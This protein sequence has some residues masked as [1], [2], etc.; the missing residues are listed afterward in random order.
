MAYA[1]GRSVNANRVRYAL[2]MVIMMFTSVNINLLVTDLAEAHQTHGNSSTVYSWPLSGHNDTGWVTLEATNADPESGQ[3]A[4]QDWDILFPPGAEVSNVSMEIMVDGSSGISIYEPHLFGE[5]TGETFFDWSGN[6]GFG[7]QDNLMGS[8]PHTGRLAPFSDTGATW[9]LPAGASVTDLTIEA[10][11]PLDPVVSFEPLDFKIGDYE[12]DPHDGRMYV[13][14]ENSILQLDFHS[15]PHAIHF[16][17]IGQGVDVYDIEIDAS[18]NL[19]LVATSDGITS[20]SLDDGQEMQVYP[21]RPASLQFDS[22]VPFRQIAVTTS[23][24]YAIAED[25]LFKYSSVTNTWALER[26]AGTANWPA[27]NPVDTLE[28]GGN[29]LVALYGG[30]VA[31]WNLATGSP[32]NLWS[33]SNNLPS[34]NVMKLLISGGEI[35]VATA[36][37]GIGRYDYVQGFWKSPWTTSNGLSSNSV[38]GIEYSTSNQ[39]NYVTILTEDSLDIYNTQSGAF[40]LPYGLNSL[41][42]YGSGKM[43][44]LMWPANNG[45]RSPTGLIDNL[46]VS[47]GSGKLARLTISP[48]LL[49]NSGIYQSEILLASG[50]SSNQMTD[51]VQ[52]DSVVWVGS[53]SI[54]DRYDTVEGRWLQTIDVGDDIV[55]LTTDGTTVYAATTSSDIMT[56]SID[57]TSGILNAQVALNTGEEILDITWDSMT[58]MLVTSHVTGDEYSVK[59]INPLTSQI[60]STWDSASLG[61]VM[62]T[63]LVVRDA[64]A[65]VAT[66]DNGILRIDMTTATLLSPWISTGL[67]NLEDMPIT[68]ANGNV[69]LGLYDYGVMVLNQTT[70]ELVDLWQD[71]GTNIQTIPN[72]AITA[73][74]ADMY[75]NIYVGTQEGGVRWDTSGGWTDIP[76]EQGGSGW[77]G[78]WY[79]DDFRSFDSDSNWLWA[80]FGE[81]RICRWDLNTLQG[82]TGSN[83]F[84]EDNGLPDE[85]YSY[86]RVRYVA[87]DRVLVTSDDG[88]MIFDTVNETVEGSWDLGQETLNAVTAQ[89]DDIIYAAYVGIG[90]TRY[91]ISTSSW[92]SSWNN[93]NNILPNDEV[94]TLQVDTNNPNNL[95]VGGSFGLMLINSSTSAVEESFPPGS[96][97]SGSVEL[98]TESPQELIIHNNI[99]YYITY[100]DGWDENGIIAR[101][102]LTSMTSLSEIDVSQKLGDD[103]WVHSA[104]MSGDIL[105]IGVSEAGWQQ[106]N[107]GGIFRWNTSSDTWDS[108]GHILEPTEPIL[109]VNANV[110]GNY[111]YVAYGTDSVKQFDLQGNLVN[112]WDSNTVLGPIRDIEEY[113]GLV[114]FASYDGIAR[115]DPVNGT[116]LQ[117]MNSGDGSDTDGDGMPDSLPSES[118][119]TISA[120]EIV[121]GDIWFSSYNTEWWNGG[122][123]S[124]VFRYESSTSSWD[125][126]EDGSQGLPDGVAFSFRECSGILHIGMIEYGGNS[127]G[128]GRYKLS[129]DTWEPEWNR[130][131]GGQGQSGGLESN[132]VMG[133]ACDDSGVVYVGYGEMSG[134]GGG[135]GGGGGQ[136]IPGISRYSYSQGQWLSQLDG[137]N[138][139]YENALFYDAMDWMDGELVIGHDYDAGGNGGISRILANGTN[140]GA[141]QHFST[142]L[143]ASTAIPNRGNSL[144]KGWIIG[145]PGSDSGFSRV[146]WLAHGGQLIPGRF[147]AQVGITSG[148][149]VE[150]ESNGTHVYVVP[151]ESE[152]DY[153]GR[154][155]LEGVVLANGS[156]EWTRAWTFSNLDIIA[157]IEFVGTELWITTYGLGLWKVD[158]NTGMMSRISASISSFMDGLFVNGDILSIGVVGTSSSSAG[159]QVYNISSSS[160]ISGSLLAGLPSD[161]IRDGVIHSGKIWFATDNGVGIWNISTQEWESALTVLNGLPTPIIEEIYV[162]D[163]PSGVSELW[164]ATPVGLV[165]YNPT[166]STFSPTIDRL[167]G[168]VG[169]SVSHVVEDGGNLFL[170]HTGRGMTRPGANSLNLSTLL[171]EET[172]R[173]DQLPSNSI[174]SMAV[175]AWGIHIATDTDPITHWN[176]ATNQFEDGASSWQFG[177]W[178]PKEMVSD[179]S[180]L[181]VLF[182]NKLVRVSVQGTTHSILTT[183]SPFTSSNSVSIGQN[184]LFVVGSD[185]MW[186]WEG[187]P[188]FAPM[189]RL[190]WRRAV[191]LTAQFSGI[192]KDLSNSIHPGQT[193]T[194]V[195]SDNSSSAFSNPILIEPDI[196]D[197]GD[198]SYIREVEFP[199]ILTSDVANSPTWLSSIGM[200]YSGIWNLTEENGELDRQL[201]DMLDIS[202]I[203]ISG[204]EVT[205]RLTAPMNGS[206]MVR[207]TYD[208]ERTQTPVSGI[209][210]IDR[211]DDGGQH[212]QAEWSNA[213]DPDFA[214]YNLYLKEDGWDEHPLDISD[215]ASTP[216][217]TSNFWGKSQA[218]VN[219]AAGIPLVDGNEYWAV[220]VVEYLDG[221]FGIPSHPFGPAI[222]TDEIP[223]PPEWANAGPS[224]GG[225]DGDMYVEWGGCTSIDYHSTRIYTS[226]QLVSDALGLNSH[227]NVMKDEGN[228]TLLQVQAGL[229]YW[230]ALTCVDDAGQ[231]DPANATV[232][233][234]IVPAGGLND[235][236]APP[237]IEDIEAFDTPEDEGGRITV[238]WTPSDE[239]DCMLHTILIMDSTSSDVIP[240]TA[241]EFSVATVITDCETGETIISAIGEEPLM[242]G[243]MYYIT[244]VAADKWLNEDRINVQIV[245]ATPFKTPGMEATKPDRVTFL[246]AWDVADDD[247]SAINVGWASSEADDFSHY[248]IWASSAPV[249]DLRDAWELF[250]DDPAKCACITVSNQWIGDKETPLTVV[251]NKAIYSESLHDD[252]L[253]N[254]E[255]LDIQPDETLYVTVTVHDIKGNVWLNELPWVE[256]IPVDNRDDMEAPDRLTDLELVDRPGDDGTSLELSFEKSTSSD[257]MKYAIYADTYDFNEVGSA[258]T[259]SEP[260]FI[261]ERDTNQWNFG[262]IPNMPII[263]DRLSSGEEI[264]PMM[265]VYVAVVAI[266][267]NDNSHTDNLVSVSATSKDNRNED[268][269]AYLPDIVGV[270]ASWVEGG[271]TIYVQW[272]SSSDITVSSYMIFISN[273]EWSNTMDAIHVGTAEG[274][275]IK[276][277][278]LP[279]DPTNN[280]IFPTQI[281]NSTEWWIAVVAADDNEHRHIVSSPLPVFLS[282]YVSSSASDVS[283]EGAGEGSPFDMQILN[284]PTMIITIALLISI[285]IVL[286]LIYRTRSG[287][288]KGGWEYEATW[289]IKQ[290][291][292]DAEWDS[293]VGNTPSG[294]PP[295]SSNEL[296]Q[297]EPIPSTVE[298]TTPKTENYTS[299]A[300]GRTY[301]VRSDELDNL[302][303]D[304]FDE[305][306]KDDGK[307]DTSFLDDLL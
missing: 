72:N 12:I 173:L 96:S 22:L 273:K 279:A 142:D 263:V 252:K 131:Q 128:V 213:P 111:M 33:S 87:Q 256:V 286:L 232:I 136:G 288:K 77:G 54:I 302:A 76:V 133:L 163:S 154:S 66:A 110:I 160:W 261:I 241:E 285:L 103:A 275:N 127:G 190:V 280:E 284:D 276:I 301:S 2:I 237:P 50:P 194:F 137:S 31:S 109:R 300:S 27:G 247:G 205:F 116:W 34:D 220:V 254:A 51:V 60:V 94:S 9:M 282:A 185:G 121:N 6:G 130:G 107:P 106:P 99:M 225:S 14:I 56:Y 67:D 74:H 297:S 283:D 140:V 53:G 151:A 122:T 81:A 40:E 181:F 180:N 61:E 55:A 129:T 188:T 146:D 52:M 236:I 71:S 143:E 150:I 48:A 292:G 210:L 41:N 238:K 218:L 251:M 169:N 187:A 172:Y 59:F 42:L 104:G 259:P 193:Y 165:R 204:M 214:K 15:D 78:S 112:E 17:E 29:L 277:G 10:L 281:D 244:V 119:E 162:Y 153:A 198:S 80:S 32:N 171:V 44:L 7:T 268:P 63:D 43:N 23:G 170:S 101:L 271:T 155:V 182:N 289:G 49:Q 161:N 57:P 242:D 177:A 89:I 25:G 93:A 16:R 234:P 58:G 206:M 264:I 65:Y 255:V 85:D 266:D 125:N 148:V 229:P 202:Q 299:V 174:I 258:N 62:I 145:R 118:E 253:L 97:N 64:I 91:D 278:E 199:M 248:I 179:G 115:Y 209:S 114:L 191:P 156:M 19:L 88:A 139:I 68:A 83:C 303:S 231:H 98:P 46:L 20:Y 24:L 8:N 208:W 100:H 296:P 306:D 38:K 298:S 1:T 138:G 13:A 295:S 203:T 126:W 269:G 250:G 30:G 157:E 166:T 75:G 217:A 189:E 245:N 141:G 79:Y 262:S 216:D 36:D 274:S 5:N 117:T 211:P 304:L 73:L 90:V 257:V 260:I 84:D 270:E 123:N 176:A 212:L 192:S 294:S 70:G 201:Q 47:D 243:R 132:D 183:Y 39:G 134:G 102:D 195:S 267:S 226:N 293:L 228:S 21:S 4:I 240:I 120:L 307:V 290:E 11:S 272:D 215:L 113:N 200:N 86:T 167:D 175:D 35:L 95:W 223:N 235:G 82:G 158:L 197:V 221:S 249:D 164:M 144:G 246:D 305:E 92:L 291:Q 265:T 149:L 152:F 230:L 227:V 26:S 69:F 135:P 186:G 233:G 147:D 184:G 196:G 224:D 178:P 159:L 239:E 287:K 124:R 168:L 28:T 105:L 222:P 3:S 207:L 37:A 18:N 108:A 219:T 45:A